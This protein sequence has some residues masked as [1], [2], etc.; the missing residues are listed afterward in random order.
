MGGVADGFVG[1]FTGMYDSAKEFT[2]DPLG[3]YGNQLISSSK[4][5][6]S[7]GTGVIQNAFSVYNSCKSGGSKGF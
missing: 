2:R 6:F 5:G 7:S 4:F 3:W 1:T